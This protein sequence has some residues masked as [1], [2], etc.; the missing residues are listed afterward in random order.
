MLPAVR[1]G[2]RQWAEGRRGDGTRGSSLVSL[3]T[4]D[5]SYVSDAF[6]LAGQVGLGTAP[7]GSGPDWEVNWG[8]TDPSEAR[9]VVQAAV[10]AG[11]GWIDTAPFYGWGRSESI[12]GSALR[13]LARR[14]MLLTKCGALQ[15][16]GD[17]R[18]D[19][20]ASAIA[21]DL[22]AS[23]ARLGSSFV[24]VLQLHG[25]DPTVAIEPG[26]EAVCELIAAG[27]VRAGGLSNYPVALMDRA[28]AIG[29]VSVVQHQYSLLHRAP[30]VD[31]VIDWCTDNGVT[32][33]AWS[34]LA[35]GF[36]ADGFDLAALEP[37]DFRRRKPFADPS[38]L[39]LRL[40]R[41]NLGALADQVSL[42]MTALAIG[43][44]LA[45]GAGVIIGARSPAEATAIAS[46]RALPTDLAVV[47]EEIIS[48]AW[49]AS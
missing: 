2:R 6:E 16:R 13:G 44:V 28:R 46:Y 8:H 31:G 4:S 18:V 23:L 32:F 26:W 11:V 15:R 17:G 27:R 34:P 9:A 1:N 21:A 30:E 45:R 43:W 22:D 19:R 5:N 39:N 47:V 40:M 10:D 33:L 3:V 42:S 37:S 38:R 7:L 36:L 48:Q 25:P 14:P 35:S 49:S 12:I 29:P 20:S 24:D 41:R